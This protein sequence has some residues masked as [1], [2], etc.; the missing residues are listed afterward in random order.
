MSVN[1]IKT[2]T[3]TNNS[4][5]QVHKDGT[6][7]MFPSSS[8]AEEGVEGIVPSSDG[9][10]TWHLAIRLDAMLQAVQLPAG[11]AHLDASL[12]NMDGDALTLERKKQELVTLP[13]PIP[14]YQIGHLYLSG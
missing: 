6:G 13:V 8:L 10:I 9:L 11:I 1:L 12:A 2:S 5:F 7:D 3:H 14:Y 4:W